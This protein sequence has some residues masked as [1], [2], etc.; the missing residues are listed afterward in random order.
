[1][2]GGV[3]KMSKTNSPERGEEVEKN[4]GNSIAR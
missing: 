3:E 4:L 1:M 2:G